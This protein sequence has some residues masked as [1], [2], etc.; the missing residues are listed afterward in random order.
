[1]EYLAVL[2]LEGY[3]F[4]KIFL[5]FARDALTTSIHLQLPVGQGRKQRFF[6][7][8]AGKGLNVAP[9]IPRYDIR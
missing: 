6:S 9:R 3:P 1:M 7:D 2:A 8:Q 4:E 5:F